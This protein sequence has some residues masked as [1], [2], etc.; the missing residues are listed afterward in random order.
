[1]DDIES[2]KLILPLKYVDIEMNTIHIGQT[3][4]F[5]PLLNQSK[6]I[7]YSPFMNGIWSLDVRDNG[8]K[9]L[10]HCDLNAVEYEWI[11]YD[12]CVLPGCLTNK[13]CAV[14]GFK[15]LIFLFLYEDTS[16][17]GIWRIGCYDL[18]MHREWIKCKH[19]FPPA[20]GSCKAVVDVDLNNVHFLN[21]SAPENERF[22]FK[23]PFLQLIPDELSRFYG[24]KYEKLVHGFVRKMNESLS[25]SRAISFDLIQLIVNFCPVFLH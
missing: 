3:K 9:K 14:L 25:S 13:F 15:H 20:F 4:V 16:N 7:I 5:Y 6:E 19:W 18:W 24:A 12:E 2:G 10:M 21:V 17:K 8:T 22:H 11:E 1:M 23:M